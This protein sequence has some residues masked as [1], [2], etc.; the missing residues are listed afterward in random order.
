[1]G[2]RLEAGPQVRVW[3][4]ASDREQAKLDQPDWVLALAFTPDGRRLVSAA[5]DP[6]SRFPIRLWE[7]ASGSEVW[8]H[9]ETEYATVALAVSPDGGV[10]AAGGT[11]GL[12]RLWDLA[13][14]KE[15]RKLAG[16]QGPVLA[17]AFSADGRRLV[18]GGRD[19]TALIWDVAGVLP[20][21]PATRL[22]AAEPKELWD[23]LAGCGRR[24][25]TQGG[26]PPGPSPDTGAAA[27]RRDPGQSARR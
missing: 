23:A 7:V 1:M 21:V 20:A 11:D 2:E 12:I 19:T 4:G 24:R 22:G 16:H 5:F 8:R 3:D 9:V 10:I 27:Y 26:A 15:L 17:V 14:R 6:P 18:S 25:C 13:T